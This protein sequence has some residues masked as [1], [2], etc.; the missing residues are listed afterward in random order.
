MKNQNT[1]VVQDQNNIWA[2]IKATDLPR[3]VV[4]FANY[5]YNTNER[6]V[7]KQKSAATALPVFWNQFP[8]AEKHLLENHAGIVYMHSG[9]FRCGTPS[10]SETLIKTVELEVDECDD[11]DEPAVHVDDILDDRFANN[12]LKAFLYIMRAP[13]HVQAAFKDKPRLFAKLS[14]DVHYYSDD[15]LRAEDFF[16]CEPDLTIPAG[17]IVRV[18]MASRMGDLGITTDL[19]KSHGYTARVLADVL[20][21][22]TDDV[23]T[24]DSVS[25][26][27]SACPL[28]GVMP[29]NI[30][31]ELR[32][33]A[34]VEAITRYTQ[35]GLVVPEEWRHELT[36]RKLELIKIN[37]KRGS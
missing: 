37:R 34:L 1:Y 24:Y 28:L 9:G 32:I 13:A 33:E 17:T 31:T 30:H 15:L 21:D 12:A 36:N 14:K 4:T 23:T 10:S 35:A 25:A 22:F 18:V 29:N 16:Q 27:T 5:I 7:L 6:T 11:C 19:S 20:T 2:L 26:S 8:V 3:D